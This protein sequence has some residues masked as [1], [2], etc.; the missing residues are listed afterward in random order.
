MS[1]SRELE[2]LDA[3]ASSCHRTSLGRDKWGLSRVRTPKAVRQRRN[4]DHGPCPGSA[5]DTILQASLARAERQT[6]L[7]RSDAFMR[8]R[9]RLPL[10]RSASRGELSHDAE[11]GLRSRFRWPLDIPGGR[12]FGARVSRAPGFRRVIR[13]SV[14]RRIAPPGRWVLP[15]R[16]LTCRPATPKSRSPGHTFLFPRKSSRSLCRQPPPNRRFFLSL[17]ADRTQAG[18]AGGPPFALGLLDLDGFKPI[19]DIHGH[20]IG[21]T[22]HGRISSQ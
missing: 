18:R 19:N 16:C 17:L 2:A 4:G 11:T 12:L 21:D 5:P 3:A 14:Q 13:T 9:A 8:P 22:M 6:A 15:S 7:D 10:L 20:P 1:L